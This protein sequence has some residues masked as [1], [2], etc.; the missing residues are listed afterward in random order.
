MDKDVTVNQLVE[1]GLEFK[2]QKDFQKSINIL[3]KVISEFPDYK[4][5]NGVQVVI[6]GNYY[7]LEKY[8]KT[9]Y[10]ANKVLSNNPKIELANLL[11][12][13]SYF[14]LNNH[15]KAFEILFNYLE[16]NLA[17]LFKDTLE[18]LLDGLLNEYGARYKDKI[19]YYAK[20]NNVSIPPPLAP[21]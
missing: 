20:K 18:E 3:E 5:V 21:E 17:I 2:N 7:N 6:A 14:N 19:I 13:L 4:K 15:E 10:Y 16:N 8:D 11:L 12:Y 9:I 1:R